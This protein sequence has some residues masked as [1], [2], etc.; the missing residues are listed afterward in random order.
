MFR[1]RLA[2]LANFL[3]S[4][5][6]YTFAKEIDL[7][8]KKTAINYT[9]PPRLETLK[10]ELMRDDNPLAKLKS[11]YNESLETRSGD[12][13]KLFQGDIQKAKDFE[14]DFPDYVPDEVEQSLVDE[15]GQDNVDLYLFGIGTD[16]DYLVTDD[17]QALLLYLLDNHLKLRRRR[18][19]TQIKERFG[20]LSF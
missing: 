2:N 5:G 15:Y 17:V 10:K 1:K 18:D 8:L 3:D 16:V 14:E 19:K 13:V 6:H 20:I 4:Q 7:Y 11:V 12:L 9:L